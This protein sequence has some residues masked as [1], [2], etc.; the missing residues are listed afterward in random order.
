MGF[1]ELINRMT[2]AAERA[3]G[4]GFAACFTDDGVY[5]D[6]IYGTFEGRENISK[7]LTDKFHGDAEDL[8]WEMVDPMSDDK[9]GYATYNFSFTSTMPDYRGKRV[10]VQAMSQFHLRDGL[11]AEYHEMAN[12]GIPM[13]QLGIPAET[14]ARVFL[15]SAQKIMAKPELKSHLRSD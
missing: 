15:R 7:M 6:Y 11:I 10:V 1:S 12:G 14:M 5:H 2:N 8:Q 4:E 3:D 9:L 13:A